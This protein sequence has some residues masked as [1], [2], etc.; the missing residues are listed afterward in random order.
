MNTGIRHSVAVKSFACSLLASA[1][2]FISINAAAISPQ[3]VSQVPLNLSEG[4]SPNMILSLD[5]SG[6][7]SWS[8]VPDASHQVYKDKIDGYATRRMRA[9]NANPM[10]YD[11]DVTY[12]IPP[13][14]KTDGSEF[15]LTTKFTEAPLNGF[16]VP[17]ERGNHAGRGKQDLRTNYRL[18]REHRLGNNNDSGTLSWANHPS[19]FSCSISITRNGTQTCGGTEDSQVKFSVT[20]TAN[21]Q[22]TAT[23]VLPDGS[24]PTAYCSGRSN[25]FTVNEISRGVPAYYYEFDPTMESG[26]CAGKLGSTDEGGEKCHR[27]KFVHSEADRQNFAIWYSFYRS[28]ALATLS[29]ASI[30]FYDLS[31][32]VR[33]TWQNLDTCTSFTSSTSGSGNCGDNRLKPFTSSH[34][35]EF[36]SWLRRI[37]FNKSTP[38][39]ATMQRAGEYLKD[40]EPWKKYPHGL[41]GTNTDENTYACRP[42]Y[43][44]LMT[45]GMWN[46]AKTL[47]STGRADESEF[48]TPSG[49]IHAGKT[50]SKQPPFYG[51]TK[52]TLADFAMHYWATDLRPNLDNKLTPYIPYRNDNQDKEYWDPRNNPAEWQHM[53]NFIMGLGLSNALNSIQWDGATHAGPGYAALATGDADWPAPASDSQNNVYDLWHAAINSRGDF[54]SVDSPQAM[55][56]AFKDILTRIADRKSSAAM[57]GS[58][59]ELESDGDPNDPQDRLATYFYQTT[60]DSA[61]GWSGD[62]QKVKKYRQYDQESGSYTDIVEVQ[63]SASTQLPPHSSRKIYIRGAGNNL[64][65]FSTSNAGAESTEGT[66]AYYLSQDPE[67]GTRSGRWQDRLNYLRGD[68]SQEGDGADKFRQRSSNKLGDFLSSQPVI[69]AGAR[70]LEGFANNLEGTTAYT[71]FLQAAANRPRLLYVG[72]NGGMLHAFD[73][74]TLEEKFAFIPTA[75][76]PKLNKL[77]GK[78]YSHEFYVDG[79]PVIADIYD[80]SNWRTILVG[81]LRGGGQSMF[82]L[83]VTDPGTD[84]SGIKLLWELDNSNFPEDTTVKMGY[85][86]PEPTVARLHNGKW[87][88]VTGNGYKAPGSSNGTAAL[89]IID[90]LT[91]NMIKSLEVESPVDNMENGLSSPRLVDYDS[92]GVADYA[93]AGDLH[94]NLWRFDLLGSDSHAPTLV[95]P[96][97]GSYGSKT[98]PDTKF[99]VSYGGKPMFIA[100]SSNGKAQPITAAP[101]VIRHPTRKG[102][103]VVFGTG[104]YFEI[105]DKEGDKGMAQTLYGIWDQNTK[106]ELTSAITTSRSEL[107]PQSITSE[108]TGRGLESDKDR[109]VRIMS[110]NPIEWYQ[111]NDPTKTV[112]KQGWY[113][114]L[115]VGSSALDGEMIVENMRT[116]GNTLL[117]STLVPNADPCTSGSSNWLYAINPATGGRTLHHVFDTRTGTQVVSAIKFGSEGGVSISQNEV[118]FKANA[119]G[120]EEP[121]SPDPNSMGRQTWR[122]IEDI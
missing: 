98:G 27:I 55:V 79:T 93:Y 84:G 44:V 107:V 64:V 54:Y 94:G 28:R 104:K 12:E 63:S 41:G 73:A 59:S 76:F 112:N 23:Y 48:T 105:G 121:L 68:S 8:F 5:E 26:N 89:L 32:D 71:S 7:M 29:A 60:F 14:F 91:G 22:C 21:N 3:E 108:S 16:W 115:Q 86:F 110:N 10:A 67:T 74:N 45:D 6:S 101:S 83:D 122:M 4:V 39:P 75:V 92:D 30:A 88:V 69:V 2:L 96:S 80:G 100:E 113:L 116:L 90:A 103:L 15:A 82:A 106:A 95:P 51:A 61:D 53:S 56:Q 33:F 120:D 36:Y 111:G 109:D 38:L 117:F 66:L 97:N 18:A 119:P 25:S 102:Y 58:M 72:G 34:R 65:S 47:G 24:K 57:P 87:A 35:G 40:P 62:I 17:S 11:P 99:E 19:D 49:D 46:E 1:L 77:T 70:Y 9:V 85:S 42:S 118:G 114:D 43:H 81:T 37:Y 50:Y 13:A 20:R 31:T 78:N 52:N